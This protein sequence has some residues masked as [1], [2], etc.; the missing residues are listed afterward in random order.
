VPG[1]NERARL[2]E[3][4]GINEYM[5]GLGWKDR[6][7]GQT[8]DPGRVSMEMGIKVSNKKVDY[9]LEKR[10]PSDDDGPVS[11][12]PLRTR[13]GKLAKHFRFVRKN[14]NPPLIRNWNALWLV[15]Q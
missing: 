1:L 10:K 2:E 4:K 7:T 13:A 3:R 11:F 9:T 14:Y 6:G 5:G 12:S 8:C 15:P